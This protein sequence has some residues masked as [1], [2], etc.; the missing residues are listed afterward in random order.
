M[1]FEIEITEEK[2]NPLIDRLEL[3]F[4][5]DHFGASTPNRLEIKKKITAL[6]GSD[7]KLTIVKR[8]DTHFGATYS[9][10]KVYIYDNPNELQFFEPF[11]IKV[12]NLEK[13]KRI[14]IYQLKRRKESYKHLFK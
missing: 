6:Q 11:H 14:E 1:S 2:K 8:L 10:G 5:V 3:T 4:R 13:D 9:I 12:R 7:E